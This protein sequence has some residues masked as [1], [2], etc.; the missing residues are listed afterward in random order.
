MRLATRDFGD[1]DIEGKF[2]YVDLIEGI[3]FR[4][5]AIEENSA[6]NDDENV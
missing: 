3:L 6:I 2:V 1:F 5:R 4:N